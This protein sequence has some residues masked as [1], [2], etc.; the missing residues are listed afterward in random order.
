MN[1][2]GPPSSLSGRF[3]GTARGTYSKRI[4]PL[5]S[6][7]LDRILHVEIGLG[8]GAE[9]QRDHARPRWVAKPLRA[10][11]D[12]TGARPLPPATQHR[13]GG[14]AQHEVA[15]RCGDVEHVADPRVAEQPLGE[16]AA[17]HR[18]MKNSTRRAVP[19]ASGAPANEYR[20]V[21]PAALPPRAASSAY[22]RAERE[23]TLELPTRTCRDVV[24]ERQQ[25]QDPGLTTSAGALPSPSDRHFDVGHGMLWQAST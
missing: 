5:T 3:A 18:R 2:R 16:H 1:P 21:T 6:Q 23:R 15:V 22:C 12:S 14:R 17:R 10:G 7:R 9:H 4:R 24:G 13:R 11:S 25:M 19:L 8:A 20:R